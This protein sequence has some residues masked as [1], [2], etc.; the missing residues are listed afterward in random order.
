MDAGASEAPYILSI[1]AERSAGTSGSIECQNN[2]IIILPCRAT[3]TT[4]MLLL[5]MTWM[6]TNFW[7]CIISAND[8]IAPYMLRSMHAK[9]RIVVNE[10]A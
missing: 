4:A 8:D 9:R 6:Q 2:I 3:R 7:R 5:G 10:A 1:H